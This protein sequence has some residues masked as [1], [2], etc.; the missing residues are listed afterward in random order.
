[1][2]NGRKQK[3]RTKALYVAA[4]VGGSTQENGRKN[5]ISFIPLHN[6]PNHRA[7]G[8]TTMKIVLMTPAAYVGV[9]AMKATAMA[10]QEFALSARVQENV[11]IKN[12]KIWQIVQVVLV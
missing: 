8:I 2:G 10:M 11:T 5:H 3:N 6:Q 12:F 1:M 4:L 9:L 7:T